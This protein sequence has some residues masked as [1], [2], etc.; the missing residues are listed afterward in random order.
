[1]RALNKGWIGIALVILFGASLFFFRGSS[2]YSNLFNSDNFVANVSGTQ[3][4]TTQF[5]RALEMN[6]G[7]FS[8]MIGQDLTGEQ[9]RAFQIHQLVLQNLINNAIFENEFDKL[10]F[11]LDD[12]T[13]ASQTKKRFPNIYINNKINDEALNTFLRQ[14]RLKIEDLVNIISYETRANVFDDLFFEKKYPTEFSKKINLY[15]N[16]TREISLI[17]IPYQDIK[18]PNFDK[19]NIK[20]DDEELIEYYEENSNKYMSIEKR[21]ISYLVI[22]KNNYKDNFIPSES[23]ITEYFNTNKEMFN[24]PEGRT[25]KQFNFKSKEEAENFKRQTIGLSNSEIINYVNEKNIKFNEFKEVNR[26]QVLEELSNA[27]FSLNI[28][29]VSNVITTDLAYHIVILDEI[30][31]QKDAVL[32]DAKNIIKETL[33]NVELDNYFNDLKLKINQQLLNGYSMIDL[34]NENNLQINK[35]INISKSNDDN[36]N[37]EQAIINTSFT[38]NKEF[39]SDVFDFDQNKA[40]IIYVDNIYPSEIESIDKAFENVIA[41]FVKSKKLD[42]ANKILDNNIDY[43]LTKIRDIFDGVIENQFIKLNSNNLPNQL[44]NKIFNSE[45]GIT[46]FSSDQNNVYFVKLE[47]IEI[48]TS[49]NNIKEISLKSEFKNAFGSEI[50]KT[51]NISINDELINGLLSQYK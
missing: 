45:M 24:T 33:T 6:I 13:V 46:T 11:I 10:K 44:I 1:M 32:N 3:I 49:A 2:R 23:E 27:I 41:D 34:A 38:L 25:F 18:I 15:D 43:N 4:S 31:L 9:I 12:S 14:Q 50:I 17:K 40:Y 37:L 35:L 30:L 36:N 42:Y 26:N 51:K 47:N 16:Q 7:Q 28:G 19:E 5:M 39:L 20:I 48:E 21:D 29:E 8:Q 22:D